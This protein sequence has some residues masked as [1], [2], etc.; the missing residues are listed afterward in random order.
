M[1]FA[2]L[3]IAVFV[4]LAGC[5]STQKPMEQPYKPSSVP[6]PEAMQFYASLREGIC[7]LPIFSDVTGKHREC[8]GKPATP[9]N[10]ANPPPCA[11]TAATSSSSDPRPDLPPAYDVPRVT[12]PS[13]SPTPGSAE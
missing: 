8:W 11:R 3:I 13:T 5:A 4:F 12:D 1:Q 7:P 9:E 10:C 2:R 6:S